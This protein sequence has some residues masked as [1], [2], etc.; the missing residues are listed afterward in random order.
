MGCDTATAGRGILSFLRKLAISLPV[1]L[2]VFWLVLRDMY[3]DVVLF[4]LI[5]GLVGAV[6]LA[7]LDLLE[8]AT[9]QPVLDTEAASRLG[10]MESQVWP[11]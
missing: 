1:N 8:N 3:F 6:L 7:A 2:L 5:S 10:P 9:A 4:G 11:A